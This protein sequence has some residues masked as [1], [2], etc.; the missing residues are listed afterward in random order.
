MNTLIRRHAMW[1]LICVATIFLCSIVIKQLHK[2]Q[3]DKYLTSNIFNLL[4]VEVLCL[5]LFC[6]VVPCF[7]L[8]LVII[9]LRIAFLIELMCCI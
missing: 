9:L 5:V 1:H 3:V 7:L 2:L 8:N 6:N 4:C